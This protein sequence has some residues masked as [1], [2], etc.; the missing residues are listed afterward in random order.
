MEDLE[1]AITCL[2]QALALRPHG[3]PNLSSSLNN[4]GCVVFDRFKRLG[5]LGKMEDLEEAII[6]HRQALDL[7]VHGHPNRSSSL[8]N[9]ANALSTR[10]EQLGGMKDLE[11][12]IICHR[13][14]LALRPHG[15]PDHPSSLFNLALVM[16]I[17]FK[18]SRSNDDLL[19]AAKYF[20]EAKNILPTGHPHQSMYG[21]SLASNLLMQ[22]DDI[23]KLDESLHMTTKAYEL[24][25]HAADHSP[26][27]MK[28]RFDAAVEWAGEAHRRDHPS[29]VHAYAKSLTLLGRRLIMAPTVES[30]QNLL[31][32]V[33]K[34]RALA[35]D[36]A[37]NSINR[38]EFRSAI[39]LL[40]QGRAVL[41]SKLRGYRHPLDKLCT[42]DK[43]LFDQFETLSGQLECLAMSV[44][45]GLPLAASELSESNM[46]WPSSLGP[47]FEAK[48]QQHRIL[49]EKW[50][51]VVDKT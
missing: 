23:S 50:D 9:L 37:S 4:L 24:F 22:C 47:S 15:H 44:E 20:S 38:G 6:C 51:D 41:W 46:E 31:A 5:S 1:E 19:E 25:E 10:F 40:E 8:I 45:S 42:I 13:Q 2:R 7:R 30:Q 16:M 39:E 26:S 18:Q 12:A 48:M 32:T 3:H 11:E 43:E 34:A 35:L 21:F 49:S 17:C 29:A 27:G 14:A 33:P 28:R 36:A